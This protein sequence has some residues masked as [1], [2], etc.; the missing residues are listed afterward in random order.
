MA[1]DIRHVHNPPACSLFVF[2]HVPIV[3]SFELD[4]ELGWSVWSD[5]Y[6]V[7]SWVMFIP[8]RLESLHD[9]L[10]VCVVDAFELQRGVEIIF[11]FIPV[12][13]L[14][15]G[16]WTD[17]IISFSGS[18]GFPLTTKC[19]PVSFGCVKNGFSSMFQ[20]LLLKM[21]H[22]VTRQDLNT[23]LH[24]LGDRVGS[25]EVLGVNIVCVAG[26]E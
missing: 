24:R 19:S 13:H 12:Q 21:S 1:S 20:F 3:L 4:G 22:P 23:F 17:S 14:W 15:S 25:L 18:G 10:D 16:S 11:R 8:V 26:R 9:V 2:A 5:R 6:I 7:F